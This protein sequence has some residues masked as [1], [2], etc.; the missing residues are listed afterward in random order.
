MD[1]GTWLIT[2]VLPKQN[3]DD[4]TFGQLVEEERK[5]IP[6]YAPQ[7]TDHNLSDPG[8]TLIDLFAWLTEITLFRINLIRDSH[9]L[10]YL[11]LLGFTPLPP[12]PAS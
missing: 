8:I 3:L 10:K 11:K 7:W 4:K 6:R 12:L 1:T 2:M 9:K 5:L